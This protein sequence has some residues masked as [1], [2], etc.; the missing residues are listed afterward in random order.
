MGDGAA[1]QGQ[2]YESFNFAALH[3]LPIIFLVEN[4]L[5]GMGTSVQRASATPDFYTR[6]HYI[7]GIM[8]DG[9]N[10]LHTR[11][12]FKFAKKYVQEKGPLVVEAVTYRYQGHSASDP[13]KSY[14]EA[15]EVTKVKDERDPIT[16]VIGWLLS[17]GLATE[18]EI[19]KIET[20]IAAE[21]TK[22][23][24]IAKAAP[25]PAPEALYSQIY[26]SENVFVRG[27]ELAN[28]KFVTK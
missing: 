1:N 28:S 13:G 25:F 5:Y 24:E 12:I 4:N 3:K 9:Q 20:D 26:D 10:V 7:P 8:Y 23:N 2:V 21:V 14:R 6:G 22:E 16:R 15:S 11:E 18:D 17:N 27:T 19:K